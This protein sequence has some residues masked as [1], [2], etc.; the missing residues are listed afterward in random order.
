MTTQTYEFLPKPTGRGVTLLEMLIVMAI[1]SIF[2][3]GAVSVLTNA[4][5]TQTEA[6][7]LSNMSLRAN[8]ELETWLHSSFENIQVGTHQIAEAGDA[9]TTGTVLIKP[10]QNTRLLE[11]TVTLQRT[12]DKGNRRIVMNGLAGPGK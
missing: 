10:F 4:R 8:A 5:R 7:V 2:L 1:A 6:K 12:T 3:T 11:I 9:L